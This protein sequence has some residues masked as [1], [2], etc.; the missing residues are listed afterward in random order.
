MRGLS[1]DSVEMTIIMRNFAAI[2]PAMLL[3]ANAAGATR[4]R[5]A[6]PALDELTIVF[7]SAG[8]TSFAELSF[9]DAGVIAHHG[10]R[11]PYTRRE[12]RIAIRVD[13]S[14]A[15]VPASSLDSTAT[16]TPDSSRI[17]LTA[18]LVNTDLRCIIRIDGVA[19]SEVPHLID[20]NVRAGI[21]SQ[22]LITIDVPTSASAGAINASILWDA[23][24]D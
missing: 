8:V 11:S 13:R 3:A 23:T 1:S 5:A 19:L 9:L 22:H 17:A 6:M 18:R 16:R 12:Q 15:G 10:E 20:A 21:A 7:I 2:S 4:R 24:T 14:R